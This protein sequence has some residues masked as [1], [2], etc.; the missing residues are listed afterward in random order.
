MEMDI[1]TLIEILEQYE[2]NMEVLVEGEFI[3]PASDIIG[4]REVNKSLIITHE[5]C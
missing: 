3:N 1:K 5:E 4:I 2:E